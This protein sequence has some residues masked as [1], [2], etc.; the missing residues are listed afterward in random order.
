M[1]LRET[2]KNHSTALGIGVCILV[3]IL[4]IVIVVMMSGYASSSDKYAEIKDNI[5]KMWSMSI[6][7]II[8]F[9]FAA[10]LLYYYSEN[11]QAQVAQ[12]A[13]VAA[14]GIVAYLNPTYINLIIACVA[15]GLSFNSLAIAAIK[16]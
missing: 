12:G 3:I 1:P 6:I 5:E 11:T 10:S 7:G 13:Q 8:L 9:I 15:L 16:R 2:L 4:Y 14:Q